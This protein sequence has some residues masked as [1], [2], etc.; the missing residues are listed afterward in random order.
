MGCR[1]VEIHHQDTALTVRLNPILA[2][3]SDLEITIACACLAKT[4]MEL[5]DVDTV[6]IEARNLDGKILFSRI[7]TRDNLFLRDDY[8]LPT[9]GTEIT[10]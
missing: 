4:C 7:L 9:E 2:E 10:P 1:I 6:Q 8:T 5:T 3:K